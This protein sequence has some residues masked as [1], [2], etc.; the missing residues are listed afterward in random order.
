MR[1]PIH[2]QVERELACVPHGAPEQNA[3]RMVFQIMRENDL[4]KRPERPD[5]TALETVDRTAALI[6]GDHP[7]VLGGSALFVFGLRRC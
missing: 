5:S 1:T 7:P 2:D 6:R 3:F 4:G